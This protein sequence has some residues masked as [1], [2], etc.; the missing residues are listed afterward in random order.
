[1]NNEKLK[2]IGEF[3][4]CPSC[5]IELELDDLESRNRKFTCPECGELYDLDSSSIDEAAES[6]IKRGK[7]SISMGEWFDIWFSP[8]L[9]FGL[10]YALIWRLNQDGEGGIYYLF[11]S[12]IILIGLFQV[13]RALMSGKLIF[14]P[15][16]DSVVNKKAIAREMQNIYRWELSE[17]KGNTYVFIDKY[18]PNNQE[19]L[20]ICTEEGYYIN[21]MVR[22]SKLGTGISVY[23]TKRL[24]KYI[25][26][27]PGQI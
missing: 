6:I 5:D 4:T 17:A 13:Y 11:V 23:Q 21:C 27:L 2:N 8:V 3:V 14:I 18:F 9:L 16:Q 22:A 7:V 26:Q 1:M 19:I 25:R 20:I 24:V 12:V 10:S 15:N